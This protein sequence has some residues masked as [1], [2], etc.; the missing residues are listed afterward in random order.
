MSP[1]D[2]P[3]PLLPPLRPTDTPLLPNESLSQY[4]VAV[5]SPWIDLASPDPVISNI[6]RQILNLELAYAS[7]CGIPNVIVKAPALSSSRGHSAVMAQFA[8]AIL[9]ALSIGPYLHLHVLFSMSPGKGKRSED[10]S[11]LSRFSQ[12]AEPDV[13]PDLDPWASWEAWDLLRGLCKY[14]G[15]ISV[16]MLNTCPYS[17][18]KVW[19]L[20][21]N[22]TRITKTTATSANPIEVVL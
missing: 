21:R 3:I 8:R 5:T 17:C 22:S 1:E 7:F 6:S 18:F 12:V 10:S 4:V 19:G 15:R 2:V 14:S 16:G 9:E 11:H 20:I 13:E